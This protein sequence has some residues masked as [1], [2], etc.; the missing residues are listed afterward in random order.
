MGA[1]PPPALAG[2]GVP[3]E[4][5]RGGCGSPGRGGRGL[6]VN[7]NPSECVCARTERVCESLP[8]RFLQAVA[9]A[10]LCLQPP[11]ATGAQLGGV[12]LGGSAR[13]PGVSRASAICPVRICVSGCLG[14]GWWRGGC[15][16]KGCGGGGGGGGGGRE[17][18]RGL[19]VCL[20]PE[21][22]PAPA[23]YLRV[24]DPSVSFPTSPP[25]PDGWCVPGLCASCLRPAR[26]L[27][28]P[29][30]YVLLSVRTAPDGSGSPASTDPAR[31]RARARVCVCVSF[32]KLRGCWRGNPREARW[33]VCM[34]VCVSAC[35]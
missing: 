21:G 34:Y 6:N 32:L 19:S 30:A 7:R 35:V 13:P 20:N 28:S 14:L 25:N 24:L 31:A 17:R 10:T 12:G 8:L 33:C 22:P 11:S 3:R 4:A 16:C 15:V 2:G 1:Y 18:R 27:A 5:K 9:A 29:A 23:A 26:R